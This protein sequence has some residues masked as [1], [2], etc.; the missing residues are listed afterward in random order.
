MFV[1]NEK[2]KN[3]KGYV[4]DFC[5]MSCAISFTKQLLL[6]DI[7]YDCPLGEPLPTKLDEK[8]KLNR[9]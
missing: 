3:I 6:I 5:V 2:R 8:V 7:R 4:S 1:T 9:K